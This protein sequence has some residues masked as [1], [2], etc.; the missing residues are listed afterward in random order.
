MMR[1]KNGP[2]SAS[3]DQGG[4]ECKVE[5]EEE[6]E[7]EVGGCVMMPLPLLRAS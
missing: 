7:E 5:E 1:R 4:Q 6:E 3:E 2:R